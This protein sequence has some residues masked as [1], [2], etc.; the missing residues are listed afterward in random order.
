MSG[1][2]LVP[3]LNAPPAGALVPG[4]QP[5][6]SNAV[7]LAQYVIVFGTAG[8]VFI[9]SGAPAA[10]NPP[11][12]WMSGAA[13][14]PYGNT[15]TPASHVVIGAGQDG[16]PQVVLES[17]S[18][19][20][21]L[22]F[23]LPGTW[24]N[25]PNMF[26]AVAGSGGTLSLNGP[27]D[28]TVN[29]QAYLEMLSAA[30]GYEGGSA[31]AMH[32]K[33]A[34]GGDNTIAIWGDNGL[35]IN[36]AQPI[37]AVKPG[38]GGSPTN[39]AQPESWHAMALA[40][41]WANDAGQVTAQYRL[42]ASPPNSVEIIGAIVATAATSSTFFTLPAAYR[43]AHAQQIPAGATGG[44]IGAAAPFITCTA[45]GALSTNDVTIGAANI[46]VFHGLISLAA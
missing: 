23:P 33:D 20:G 26:G 28:T 40:N 13:A 16:S 12:A 21:E 9:Y 18:G 43:P 8:G 19:S 6:V 15:L 44:V 2:G 34:N 32:Y 1:D 4:V 42:V 10:G 22:A 25:Y 14:D 46:V 30:A 39:P 35:L 5:G 36:A 17:S 31:G 41:S 3:P 27:T 37:N 11:I 7:I 38:T 45:A 24:T 29:D